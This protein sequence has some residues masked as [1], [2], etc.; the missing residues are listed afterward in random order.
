MKKSLAFFLSLLFIPISIYSRKENMGYYRYPAINGKTIVFTAEGDLWK[1]STGGG[2]AQRLTTHHGQETHASISP[3]G[4]FIAYTA[5]YDGPREVYL[6]SID[7]GL[8]KRL[9]HHGEGSFVVGWTPESEVLFTTRHFST[10]PNNQLVSV[11]PES[12]KE[13]L[14]P[15]NQA[16]S[17]TWDPKAEILV[18]TRLAFQGSQTKRYK[19][20]TAQNLW[21]FTRGTDEAFPLTADYAGTSK[22]P[23]WYDGRIY[24]ATDRDGTM[25]I[26]SMTPEGHDLQQQTDYIYF[27]V[28]NPEMHEGNIVYQLGADIYIYNILSETEGKITIYLASDFE[29]RREKWVSNP[30]NSIASRHL[31]EE[32]NFI[33]LTSRGRVF[34]APVK[35]GR[36]VE[37]TRKYGI[38]YK[39]ARFLPG[40]EDVIMQS[41]ESGE[42][43]YWKAPL[44]GMGEPVQLSSGSTI[45]MNDGRPSADGKYIAYTDKDLIFWLL[46][47]Q[48]R[49]KKAIDTGKVEDIGSISW[50]P[51]SRWIAYEITCNNQ[52]RR[53]KLYNIQ[54]GKS[55]IITTER[56]DSGSPAWDPEG[57]WLY[58]C[59]D[60]EF[61]P[62][63][64]GVWGPRQPEPYYD[65]TTRIYMLALQKEHK[66]HFLEENEL[67][68]Q[69]NLT[70]PVRK[71]LLRR[72]IHRQ[73]EERT[74]HV[75]GKPSSATRTARAFT[76]RAGAWSAFERKPA[77]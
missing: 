36:F 60:R 9:T 50:A 45:L 25:N 37:V 27:D 8:P 49:S 17:G 58:F 59:S 15:L 61:N 75:N 18:F 54:T 66:W 39:N 71:H 35:T 30:A 10:L 28:Q 74:W 26:W 11:D 24:F 52:N 33:T 32:G 34:V 2:I 23:M 42:V 3:D 6:M 48:D 31:S 63:V 62:R 12:L 56:L 43:E 76:P 41:D 73:A 16:S 13:T 47:V 22:D 29:Q 38:R 68:E 5:S 64:Y 69:S 51:D 57:K 46:N 65:R 55:K 7:G 70:P 67:M 77:D 4:K 14:I 19:G 21:N 20:G 1:V 44:D 40:S 53:I 72:R